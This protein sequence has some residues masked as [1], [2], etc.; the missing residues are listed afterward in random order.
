VVVL[1]TNVLLLAAHRG[2][3]FEAE[4]SRLVPGARIVVPSS[5]LR[6]LDALVARRTAGSV[7]ARELAKRYEVEATPRSRDDGV[8]DVATRTRGVVATAD[9]ELQRRLTERGIGVLVPRDRVRLELRPAAVR[10]RLRSVPRSM[11]SKAA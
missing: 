1:D 4:V 6:E 5:A 2:F 9:Q 10:Q 3:P 11:R 7:V 8:V